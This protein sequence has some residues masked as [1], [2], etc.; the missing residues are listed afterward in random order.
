[1]PRAS[2][3]ARCLLAPAWLPPA[4]PRSQATSL[5][6]RGAARRHPRSL[7]G[8]GNAAVANAIAARPRH[9]RV[10]HAADHRTGP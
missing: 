9:S 6:T 8:G 2:S 10:P 5:C 3:R 1:M 4:L 7:G